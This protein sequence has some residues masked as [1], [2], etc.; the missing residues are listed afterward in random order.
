MPIRVALHHIDQL[1]LRPAGRVRP[2]HGPPAARAALPHAGPAAIRSAIAP[3]EHFL[4]WQQDPYGNFLARVVFPK[5]AQRAEV[6]SRPGGRDDGH[7]SV[8]LLPRS[9]RPSSIRSPTRPT[10]LKDLMPFLHVSP[11]LENSPLARLHARID[12]TPPQD[13]R[14]SGR[15]NQQLKQ[16][17]GYFIRMEPGVQIAATRRSPSGAAR[18]ATRRGCW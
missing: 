13:D 15:L 10:L 9:R 3:D 14:L 16:D 11:V 2:A 12:R 1:P 6:R 7:Q 18:A 8:R 17:I 4:N 5:Q